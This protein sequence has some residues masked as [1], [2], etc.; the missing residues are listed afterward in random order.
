[1]AGM[2]KS[3][4]LMTVFNGDEDF[5][6]RLR[7][8]VKDKE[9][10][11]ENT[12]RQL[13]SVMRLAHRWSDEN[14][15]TFLPM[16]SQ[17]LRDYLIH[18]QEKGRASSTI[19]QHA[20]MISMLHRNAGLVAPNSSP[21]VGRALKKI[22]R[23]AVVS[24]ERTGQ[25]VP[26]RKQDLMAIDEIWQKSPRLQDLRDLAFLHLAYSTLL[27]ISELA[28]IRVRD[29]SRTEDG[30]FIIDVGYTKT[31]VKSS[32]IIK[33]LSARSSQRLHEWLESAGLYTN[34]DAYIFCRIHRSNK[35]LPSDTSEFSTRSLEEIFARA[36]RLAGNDRLIKTNKDRYAGWSGHSARVGAAQDMTQNGFAITEIMHEG[37][38]TKT[39]T[40]MRY[41]R[42]MEAHKGAMMK[43]MKEDD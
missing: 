34:P 18:L 20:A 41:I 7:N 32:G 24:G 31:I 13:L 40:L 43:L 28:R 29:L 2:S 27:R 15:R 9:A 21:E 26:F 39:E 5:V 6:L 30:L 1:M 17:D 3:G 12:W 19:S 42:N 25:A 11:S 16:S 14:G 33:A 10:F 37:T 23:T 22:N 36:W 35:P 38:W 4:G 8:F